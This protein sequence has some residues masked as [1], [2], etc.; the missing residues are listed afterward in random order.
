MQKSIKIS[1]LVFM[2]LL[3]LKPVSSQTI[4]IGELTGG[5]NALRV[6]VPFLIIAP[7]SRAGAMG[8][9]GVASTP[10]IHSQHWNPAKYAFIDKQF[11]LSLSY[12]PW[13]RNLI[14]DINLSYLAG[15]YR[16]DDQQVIS[17]SLL[18]FSMG[19]IIFTNDQGQT[20]T[21]HNPNEFAI[22]AAYSRKFADKI[23]GAIAF[24][25]IRSDL[26]GGYSQLGQSSAKA[27][28]S[29]A[30]DVS[31]YYE[32]PI[33]LDNKDHEFAL[34]LN[35]SN[36]GNKISYNDD[37]TK[38]FIPI[39]MRLGGRFTYNMDIYN[40]IG[41]MVDANKLLVPTPPVYDTEEE[42][43]II[44]GMD[45]LVSVP[46]GMMQSFYDAPGGFKEEIHEFS[47]SVG[48][49]YWYAGQFAIRAGYFD[50]H[51]TKGN[52]KYFTIGAGLKYN[53]FNLDFAY[54]VPRAGQ[55]NPLANTV[56]FT[57]GFEFEPSRRGGGSQRNN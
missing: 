56:R 47:F 21:T 1:V 25:Y 3:A 46:A 29:A 32:T 35:I 14:N 18:Y 5:L 27:G 12:T 48:L 54:L 42:G 19:D 36:M 10:D 11:G 41:I 2:L 39:N 6:G 45:P 34:G 53:V 26:T 30:A 40:A 13:L 16:L 44:A 55:A 37:A 33:S 43:V 4:D 28:S 9:A 20:M 15:Y 17:G 52:R 57:L 8:D 51:Q 49:E 22:D 24:R 50:E 7:D 38:D 23:G 31:M